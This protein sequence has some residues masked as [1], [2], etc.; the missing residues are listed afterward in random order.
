MTTMKQKT[1]KS[2]VIDAKGIYYRDLNARLREAV[3]GGV[4]KIELGNVYG[5]RYIGTDLNRPVE[6]EIHGTPGNDLGAFM[7]GPRVIVQGNAQDGCGNTMNE[8]EIIVHGHA[9]S[10]IHI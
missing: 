6:I 1:E 10:L 7:N 2:I 4:E 5:Q 8:G 3:E 9:L